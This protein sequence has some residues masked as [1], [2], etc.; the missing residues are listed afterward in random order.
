MRRKNLYVVEVDV[1]LIALSLPTSVI[2]SVKLWKKTGDPATPLAD[3]ILQ[4]ESS[5]S[6]GT[7]RTKVAVTLKFVRSVTKD[8]IIQAFE[9]ALIGCDKK[10]IADFR[11][12]MSKVIDGDRGL[13]TG[14]ILHFDWPKEGGL[15]ISSEKRVTAEIQNPEVTRRMLEVYIDDVRT[16]SKDLV[17]CLKDNIDKIETY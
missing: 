5:K 17:K 9:D 12:A 8:Q 1:Y 2:N 11:D 14:D 6:V 15:M 10:A 7:D 4:P 13:K 16:V 3:V